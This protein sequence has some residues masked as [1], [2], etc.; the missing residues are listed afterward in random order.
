[1][2]SNSSR[3]LSINSANTRIGENIGYFDEEGVFYFMKRF[4]IKKVNVHYKLLADNRA[5]L[6]RKNKLESK[7]QIPDIIEKKTIKSKVNHK[8]YIKKPGKN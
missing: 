6:V 4:E 8:K 1:M 3:S 2:T 5:T 7:Q